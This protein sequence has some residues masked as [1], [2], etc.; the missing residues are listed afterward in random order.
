MVPRQRAFH[1]SAR[2]C[3]MRRPLSLFRG[4]QEGGTHSSTHSRDEEGYKDLLIE[5]EKVYGEN[6]HVKINFVKYLRSVKNLKATDSQ[7]I[8]ALAITIKGFLRSGKS[9]DDEDMCSL[10]FS[11]FS[12]ALKMESRIYFT[13]SREPSTLPGIHKFLVAQLASLEKVD[14]KAQLHAD[15]WQAPHHV[16][17]GNENEPPELGERIKLLDLSLDELLRLQAEHKAASFQTQSGNSSKGKKKKRRKGN[18]SGQKPDLTFQAGAHTGGSTTQPPAAQ[19]QPPVAYAQPPAAPG[20][21]LL[22]QPI[23]HND[24]PKAQPNQNFQR[25]ALTIG[26]ILQNRQSGRGQALTVK[27]IYCPDCKTKQELQKCPL[28][29]ALQPKERELVCFARKCCYKCTWQGHMARHCP[30]RLTCDTCGSSQHHSTLHGHRPNPGQPGNSPNAQFD[31]QNNFA[32]M[33][34]RLKSSTKEEAKNEMPIENVMSLRFAVVKLKGFSGKEITVNAL[35]DDGSN[36]SLIEENVAR[37]L[38]LDFGRKH[39]LALKGVSNELHEEE[40]FLVKLKIQSMDGKHNSFMHAATMQAPVGELWPTKWNSFRRFWKH[41]SDVPFDEGPER[42]VQMLIGSDYNKLMMCE[43]ER[44][45][46]GWDIP[47]PIARKTPLGWTATGPLVPQPD[48]RDVRALAN[49]ESVMF[50]RAYQT[51][52]WEIARPLRKGKRLVATLTPVPEE[53]PEPN[54]SME[55]HP[56]FEMSLRANEEGVNREPPAEMAGQPVVTTDSVPVATL[57]QVEEEEESAQETPDFDC[58]DRANVSNKDLEKLVLRSMDLPK[59]PGDDEENT[60]S[61]MD[62]AAIR[63]MDNSRVLENGRY[64]V[65]VL[66]KDGEP[67]L[68]N[69]YD[70][71]LK[72]LKSLENSARMKDPKLREQYWSHI[73]DWIKKGYFRIVPKETSPMEDNVKKKTKLFSPVL[74]LGNYVNVRPSEENKGQNEGHGGPPG[75]R[76][77]SGNWKGKL[78]KFLPPLNWS[79]K[80]P[81][82]LLP[83]T[84]LFSLFLSSSKLTI[85]GE[86]SADLSQLN[87]KSQ[88]DNKCRKKSKLNRRQ[89]LGNTMAPNN[90]SKSVVSRSK[91]KEFVSSNESDEESGAQT[92]SIEQTSM[93]TSMESADT[94]ALTR[95]E[96]ITKVKGL[97]GKRKSKPKSKSKENRPKPI[98]KIQRQPTKSKELEVELPLFT[99]D[100]ITIQPKPVARNKL[101]EIQSTDEPT[102]DVEQAHSPRIISTPKPQEPNPLEPIPSTSTAVNIPAYSTVAVGGF[103]QLEPKCDYGKIAKS[104]SAQTYGD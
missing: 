49:T 21:A 92:R 61:Q 88:S 96:L 12:D 44:V 103:G 100:P 73:K 37:E 15:F 52:M 3:Q 6:R 94:S 11:L 4:K 58:Q 79:I 91:S 16:K 31:S 83:L 89:S 93:Q 41:M 17:F 39:H 71:V 101:T 33:S 62:E 90:S 43:E 56:N 68:P 46:P 64:R 25:P 36:R 75:H 50:A 2:R 7:G 95:E 26:Q 28:Y 81:T 97:Q 10:V 98:I 14:E 24:P 99:L 1:P 13:T 70:M 54:I 76:R 78:W 29:L 59:L 67:D 66:W 22:A 18:R 34:F 23:P 102:I 55:P 27:E 5:L 32:H 19:P 60:R 9:Y 69:N 72:R 47:S 74:S 45:L 85:K 53:V 8:K 20:Q 40:S 84:D 86:I 57:I 35:L 63:K 30:H 104:Q 38:G 51:I 82:T 80:K 48:H 65:S 42:P 77:S 87:I